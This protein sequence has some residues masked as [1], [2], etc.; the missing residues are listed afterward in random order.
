MAEQPE[1]EEGKTEGSEAE[2]PA[3]PDISRYDKDTLATYA[4]KEFDVTLN[5][6]KKLDELRVQVGALQ[7]GEKPEE[8]KDEE[9]APP[10]KFLKHP[11]NKRVFPATKALLARSDMIPCDAA[12]KGI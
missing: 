11:V 2:Q 6:R 4:K 8:A 12:G 3:V 1:P 10:P 9:E 7:R 5:K